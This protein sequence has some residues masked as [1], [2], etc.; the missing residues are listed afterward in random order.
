MNLCET[1]QRT[2]PVPLYIIATTTTGQTNTGSR[3]LERRSQHGK[4]KPNSHF[5]RPSI[6]NITPSQIKYF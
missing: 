1:K 3:C 5:G 6:D 2:P 4:R